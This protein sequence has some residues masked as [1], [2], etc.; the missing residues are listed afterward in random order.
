MK[1]LIKVLI[2]VLFL[3]LVSMLFRNFISMN[4]DIEQIKI[5]EIYIYSPKTKITAH[6]GYSVYTK[7][8]TLEAFKKAKEMGA[9]WIELDVRKTKDNI[10]VVI[11]D[12]NL[13]RVFKKNIKVSETKYSILKKYNIPTLE[14]I[15]AFA[16]ENNL[17]INI[18]CKEV[19]Y[20][21]KILKLIN[22]Y[23]YKDK[24]VITS[25]KYQVLKRIEQIDNSYTTL[26]ILSSIKNIKKYNLV[27]GYSVQYNSITKEKI[28]RLH[29]EGKIVYLWTIDSMVSL[30][31]AIEMEPDNIITNNL[32]DA[33]TAIN[34]A[35]Y[36]Y[37]IN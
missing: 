31:K 37:I 16:K 7:E 4:K 25:F 34:E 32:V 36:A 33:F 27:D 11:H 2:I 12:D 17:N 24:V 28:E 29:N 1:K 15:I 20:E 26:I 9:D 19:G 30:K 5:K 3:L 23:S 35:S 14:S 18:E 22:K 13:K 10:L 21:D 8:N 6:R